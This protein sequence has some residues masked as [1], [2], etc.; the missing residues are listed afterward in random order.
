MLEGTMSMQEA[1]LIIIGAVVLGALGVAAV[2]AVLLFALVGRKDRPPGP[3]EH[4]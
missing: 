3:G 1:M 2:G 4:E